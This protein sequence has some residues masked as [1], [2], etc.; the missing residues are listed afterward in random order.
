MRDLLHQIQAAIREHDFSLT[1]HAQQLTAQRIAMGEVREALLS[2]DVAVI[3]DYAE[4][5]AM[6]WLT[7]CKNENVWS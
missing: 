5:D 4:G 2:T 6:C 7:S 3:E 1:L